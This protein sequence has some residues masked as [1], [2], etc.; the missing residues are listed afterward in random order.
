MVTGFFYRPYYGKD[1]PFH[2]QDF[3]QAFFFDFSPFW[4]GGYIPNM[5]EWIE[6]GQ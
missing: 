2:L 5:V 1:N 6:F 3:G 4:L